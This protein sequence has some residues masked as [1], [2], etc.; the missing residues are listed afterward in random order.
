MRSNFKRCT[1]C[2]RYTLSSACPSCGLAAVCP[3]PMRYSPDDRYGV[4]R[5]RAIR[6]EYG[7]NG[8]YHQV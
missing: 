6:E 4:Y 5:R 7:D 3:V 8:R 2:G 1:V